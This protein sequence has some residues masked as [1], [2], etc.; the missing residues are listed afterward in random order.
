VL[1]GSAAF[2]PSL[3]SGSHN[4]FSPVSHCKRVASIDH[5][6]LFAQQHW[7]HG[8]P[9]PFAVRAPGEACVRNSG[10][11]AALANRFGLTEPLV[12]NK[13]PTFFAEWLR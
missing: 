10:R 2:T 7:W 13:V 11:L 4:R 8:K 12:S 6:T 9:H 1:G 3:N 5:C